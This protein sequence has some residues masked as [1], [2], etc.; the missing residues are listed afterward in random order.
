[1]KKIYV[2]LITA[3]KV[4]TTFKEDLVNFFIPNKNQDEENAGGAGGAGNILY[5]PSG[6]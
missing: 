2:K 4:P 3:D 6:K 5:K 1:M